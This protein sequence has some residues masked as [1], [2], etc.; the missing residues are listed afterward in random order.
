MTQIG[1]SRMQCVSSK[2]SRFTH[3]LQRFRSRFCLH[4]VAMK[5]QSLL[6]E[7]MRQA[8]ALNVMSVQLVNTAKVLA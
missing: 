2:Y 7:G 8:D 3:F 4:S 5:L 1:N 6:G